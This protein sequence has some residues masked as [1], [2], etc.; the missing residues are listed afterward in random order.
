M[1]NGYIPKKDLTDPVD[2]ASNAAVQYDS[3][4]LREVARYKVDEANLL[5]II[6]R[7]NRNKKRRY[8]KLYKK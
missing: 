3:Y 2:Y 5:S 7:R 8:K 6:F 4:I 1:G